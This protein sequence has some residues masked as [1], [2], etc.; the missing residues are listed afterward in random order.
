MALRN[1][2]I[3]EITA[4]L[5]GAQVQNPQVGMNQ[6]AQ[7]PTVDNA[8]LIMDNYRAQQSNYQQQLAQRQGLLGGMFDLGSASIMASDRRL[9]ADIER[10]DTRP[11]GLGVYSFRYRDGVVPF[12]GLMADEVAEVY[13]EAIVNVG[14]FQHVDYGRVPAW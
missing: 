9:K 5:S 14:G 10:I 13:P 12:R 7:L 2:P 3:N 1:Q 11:D 6:P 4:L 8:G